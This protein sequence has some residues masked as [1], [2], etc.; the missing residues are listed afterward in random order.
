LSR[1]RVLGD[2]VISIDT[3]RAQARMA[4]RTLEAEATMLLAHGLLHLLGL[5]HRNTQEL[6]RM[7]AR[8]DLLVAAAL[9]GEKRVGNPTGATGRGSRKRRGAA[10][11]VGKS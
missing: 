4:G 11:T 7:Q 3:A 10:E 6:R 5:D 8:T 2:I 9:T 1:T